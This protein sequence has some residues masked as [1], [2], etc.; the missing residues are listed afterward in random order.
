[1][2]RSLLF[3]VAGMFI[4]TLSVAQTQIWQESFETADGFTTNPAS[5]TDGSG[6][7]FTRTDLSNV[8]GQIL[9]T[10]ID[11][12]F[13]FGAMDTD[14][15]LPN[16][17]Q[18]LTVSFPAV[19]ITGYTDLSFKGLFA[20]DADGINFDWDANSRVIVQYSIDGGVLQDLISFEATVDAT[21]QSASEDTD[22][23]GTGDGVVLT[24]VLTEFS[25]TISGT[26]TSIILTVTIDNLDAGDEDIAFDNFRLEGTSIPASIAPNKQ[27]VV[28]IVPNP[29]NSEFVIETDKEVAGVSIFNA[30]GQLVK[31]V[32]AVKGQYVSTADL[33]NGIYIL[34]VKFVDGSIATQKVMKK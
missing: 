26:G 11:G 24:D 20:E 21:N 23:D 7:Y 29:I 3:I 31:D 10:G 32:P 8:G 5:F 34:Q 2:K 33:S 16:Q 4:V 22:F 15:E 1:M 27:N 17:A 30:V 9:I 25:K 18:G 14:G 12:S 6:D 13:F 19:D 28:K